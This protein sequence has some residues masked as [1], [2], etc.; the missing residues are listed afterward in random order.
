MPAIYTHPIYR[1]HYAPGHPES[2]ERV[3]VAVQAL[4]RLEEA[5]RLHWPD[6]HPADPGLIEGVHPAAQIQRVAALAANGGGWMDPDTYVVPAS[7]DAALHAAGAALQA[8]DDVLHGNEDNAFVL[9]RPPGHH[10]TVGRSMG[11]C[12]F[13][14]M[15]VAAHW[16]VTEGGAQRVAILDVDVHHG[17]GTQD[18]FYER[19]DVLFL[20]T[21]QFPFYPGTGRLDET[22]ENDGQGTTI[23]VPLMA[24]CGDETYASISD[25]IIEPALRRFQPDLVLVSL[26]FDAHWVDPLAQMRLTTRGYGELLQRIKRLADELCGGRLVI[27]L[28]GGYDLHAIDEC[29]RLTGLLLLGQASF[30]S[31]LGSPPASGEPTQ[32]AA[33]I[34]T[35]CATHGLPAETIESL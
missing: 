7:Y 20:S 28:E 12:L 17:N 25:R 10:A 3:R 16:A 9:M 32:A 35:V 31:R 21:H 5:D 19:P 23:N 13:N 2:P 29:A 6:V 34:E 15:A 33:R 18:I 4:Q 8:V 30:E 27:V 1:E 22:G 24:G 11:F 14:S 26:G